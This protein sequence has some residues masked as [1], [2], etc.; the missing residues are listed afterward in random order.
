MIK[1]NPSIKKKLDETLTLL[2]QDLFHPSLKTHKL[3]GKYKGYWSSS[4]GYDLRIIF[5][6]SEE[7]NERVI[8][9]HS[10]GTHDEVY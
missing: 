5:E 1:K 3:K 2:E 10:V 9:L 8:D 7:E 6:I 4:S